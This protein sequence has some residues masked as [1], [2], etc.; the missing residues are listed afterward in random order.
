M[1][2][3]KDMIWFNHNG[4]ALEVN[5]HTQMGVERSVYQFNRK[6]GSDVTA[7]IVVN[8]LQDVISSTLAAIRR[9]AYEEGWKDRGRKARKKNNFSTGLSLGQYTGW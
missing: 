4:D 3:K 5:V 8:H 6:F 7:A 2:A 9:Q 1:I